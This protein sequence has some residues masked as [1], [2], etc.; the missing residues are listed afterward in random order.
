MGETRAMK[1]CEVAPDDGAL[2]ALADGEVMSGWGPDLEAHV[3]GCES[4]RERSQAVRSVA[5]LTAGRLATLGMAASHPIGRPSIEELLRPRVVPLPTRLARV[6]SA[7]PGAWAARLGAVAA[8]VA[9]AAFW[10]AVSSFAEGTLQSFRVQRVQPVTIDLD[11]LFKGRSDPNL[12]EAKVRAALRL[13]GPERPSVT[14]TTQADAATRA[15][16]ALR[17]PANVP[18]AVRAK[19]ARFAVTTGM[20]ADIQVDGPKLMQVAR[21]ARVTDTA[22]LARLGAL[23]GAA[24]HAAASPV[25]AAIYGDVILPGQPA[26]GK[27]SSGLPTP[28]AGSPASRARIPFLVVAQ[29]RSPV[30]DVPASVDVEGLRDAALKSGAVPPALVQALASIRDWRTT[31]PIPTSAA[32]GM[33]SIEID[34]TTGTITTR[35]SDGPHFT[36]ILW[37]RDG[38][39]F[40]VAGELPEGDVIAAAR[41]LQPARS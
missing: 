34:G 30:I 25:V 6:A 33:R 1:R 2:R 5:A 13:R 38:I 12:D 26:L 27:A 35:T 11:A 3:R 10:P 17:L 32:S 37:A 23:D 41:S 36:M 40:G 20:T 4:C 39:L 16:L 18:A 8:A 9:I 21:D 24:I 15:G 7:T 19:P 29:T 31:L 14:I 22:L 28:S